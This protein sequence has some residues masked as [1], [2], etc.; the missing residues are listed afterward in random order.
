MIQWLGWKGPFKAMYSNSPAM[1]RDIFSYILLARA[2][3]NLIVK[4]IP[5]VISP[6]HRRK[7]RRA[8]FHR[9][10]ILTRE[11][12]ENHMPTFKQ[13]IGC[14][15]TGSVNPDTPKLYKSCCQA[16]YQTAQLL[17]EHIWT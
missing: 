5:S 13:E 2:P 1:S 14:V 3:S 8:I 6:Q 12:I 7:G 10:C 16:S 17:V 4:V 15:F 9:V 11:D